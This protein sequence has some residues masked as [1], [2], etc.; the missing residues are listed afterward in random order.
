MGAPSETLLLTAVSVRHPQ[1]CTDDV[2]FG[3]SGSSPPGVMVK[4]VSPPFTLAGS[5]AAVTVA[6]ARF[7][8]VRFEPA[9]T[10]DFESGHDTYTGP[11]SIVPPGASHVRQ[12][13]ETDSFE[14]VV[15]WIIGVG[16]NDQFVF[17]ATAA[18]PSL[19]L[20]F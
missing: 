18:P 9:S 16:A 1:R 4:I 7:Y 19:T 8:Q 20:T 11:T 13:V 10:F 2:V 6:G 17:K 3:F 12:L 5:G 15:T 14:G